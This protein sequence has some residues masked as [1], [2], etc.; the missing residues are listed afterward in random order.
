M[1]KKRAVYYL[2]ISVVEIISVKKLNSAVL[3][4]LLSIN[5]YVAAVDKTTSK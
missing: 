5:F 3:W 2:V 4:N 1:A